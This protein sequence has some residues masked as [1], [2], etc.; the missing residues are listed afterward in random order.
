MLKGISRSKPSGIVVLVTAVVLVFGFA[1]CG[2]VEEG[3]SG[4]SGNSDTTT[5]TYT[6]ENILQISSAA[7]LKAFADRVNNGESFENRH[8]KLTNNIDLKGIAWTPIGHDYYKPFRGYF[9][10]DGKTIFN[11]DISG[12]YVYDTVG[13][14][15]YIFYG[16]VKNLG[17]ENANIN[18]YEYVGAV[19]GYLDS[20]SVSNCRVTGPGTIKGDWYVGGVAGAV[21]MNSRVSDC[22]VASTVKGGSYVGG[23]AG[24]VINSGSSVSNCHVAGNVISE[25]NYIGGVAGF[26]EEG[27]SV[28]NCYAAGVVRGIQYIG[29]VAG[30]VIDGSVINCYATGYLGGY[31][32]VG[33]IAGSVVSS[34][35]GNVAG[36][37]ALNPAIERTLDVPS[38]VN[39]GRVA[40]Y[41]DVDTLISNV[42]WNNMWVVNAAMTQAITSR[43]YGIN[44]QGITKE[45]A[46]RQGSYITYPLPWNIGNNNPWKWGGIGYPLPIL[47]WQTEAQIPASLPEHLR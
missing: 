12:R 16:E 20:S 1:A 30:S 5:T 4:S 27:G 46:T 39:F 25:G 47:Y 17:L 40:G 3:S 41:A 9:D 32:F 7:E 24:M 35:S 45:D 33:G 34:L 23:V 13:L 6:Q 21:L 18:G 10:G 37:S 36:C 31:N 42:A 11:L 43:H 15:G 44:G 14:F 19:A 8:I 2:P 29:G 22:H 38:S 28:R 26:I